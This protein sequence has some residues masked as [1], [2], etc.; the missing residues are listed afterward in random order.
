[1]L[2]RSQLGCVRGRPPRA[3]FVNQIE[4]QT[5]SAGALS[6][7]EKWFERPR[8]RLLAH[9]E[10]LVGDGDSHTIESREIF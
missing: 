9:P 5:I 6:G 1:V 8:A 7:R 3:V 10:A 4:T 2:A